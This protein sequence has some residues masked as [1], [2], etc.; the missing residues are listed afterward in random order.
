MHVQFKFKSEYS[1]FSV[2]LLKTKRWFS[3]NIQSKYSSYYVKSLINLSIICQQ[4]HFSLGVDEVKN[5]LSFSKQGFT[6]FAKYRILSNYSQTA[7][8]ERIVIFYIYAK[9]RY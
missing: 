3:I 5:W 1:N 4:K 9:Y 6:C 7:L 8:K 2:K